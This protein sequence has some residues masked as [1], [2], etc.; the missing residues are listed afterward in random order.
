M[1]K[2]KNSVRFVQTRALLEPRMTVASFPLPDGVDQG[3]GDE[4][5]MEVVALRA[6]LAD[7]P[8]YVRTSVFA[9]FG[10]KELSFFMR[11]LY[12]A[13]VTV[14]AL[15]KRLAVQNKWLEWTYFPAASR[16]IFG[17]SRNDGQFHT[18]LP[19]DTVLFTDDPIL[20]LIL[21]P[22]NLFSDA[23]SWEEE[24]ASQGGGGGGLT[25]PKKFATSDGMPHVGYWTS[26]SGKVEATL[27]GF[28]GA[29]KDTLLRDL[30]SEHFKTLVYQV[31]STVTLFPGTAEYSSSPLE[32]ESE[33]TGDSVAKTIGESLEKGM[34]SIGFPPDLFVVGSP[35]GQETIRI[36][37]AAD[38]PQ[39]TDSQ[40]TFTLKL[41]FPES[42]P[43]VDSAEMVFV[44]SE[45]AARPNPVEASLGGNPQ[46]PPG[47]DPLV[48]SYPLSLVAKTMGP[49]D[50]YVLGLGHLNILAI[51]LGEH[52]I[53][54]N[55]CCKLTGGAGRLTLEMLDWRQEPKS[56]STRAELF[57]TLK[58]LR[59][60][61]GG[62]WDHNDH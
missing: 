2:V 40:F 4:D 58:F 37:L 16:P 20:A 30:M 43:P 18:V 7:S 61:H 8:F 46:H 35:A 6:H 51:L 49:A 23:G 26:N 11:D 53:V 38:Y 5:C 1:E 28:K 42:L 50:G 17:Y 47:E 22:N 36:G 60:E 14:D 10:K 29:S 34:A 59:Q 9:S 19:P 27:R 56:F 62:P 31:K 45:Q 24:L 15:A 44:L 12:A 55:P 54:P 21:F 25:G 41:D 33:R 39:A 52:S 32:M 3:R 57:L 48:G 13:T